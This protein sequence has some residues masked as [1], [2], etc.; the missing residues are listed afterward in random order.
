MRERRGH[1]RVHAARSL[2][3]TP[4]LGGD[5]QLIKWMMDIRLTYRSSCTAIAGGE[6]EEGR[7]SWWWSGCGGGCGV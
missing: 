5:V 1:N 6:E 2:N 3:Y 7:T 4:L